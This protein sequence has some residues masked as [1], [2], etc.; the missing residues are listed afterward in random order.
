LVNGIQNKKYQVEFGTMGKGLSEL[1]KA[2][3]KNSW[4]LLS[5]VR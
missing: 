5:I 3:C 2:L 1:A 4:I